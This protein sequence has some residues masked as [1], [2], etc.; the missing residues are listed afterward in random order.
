MKLP[1]TEPR[2]WAYRPLSKAAQQHIE[3]LLA[4]AGHESERVEA[5]LFGLNFV[6]S[7][8]HGHRRAVSAALPPPALVKELR[9]LVGEVAR[10]RHRLRALEERQPSLAALLALNA[11]PFPL[12]TLSGLLAGLQDG[13]EFLIG[14][15]RQGRGR[16][17][18]A[19]YESRSIAAV[20]TLFQQSLGVYPTA[21][22]GN[23]FET[24]LGKVLAATV[25][26][27]SEEHVHRL[28]ASV[29][30]SLKISE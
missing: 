17:A 25:G 19:D 13:A 22:Q 7:E 3:K 9:D 2:H 23:L 15:I 18:M 24:I 1:T 8:F 10:V 5:F 11:L 14:E 29:I 26:E 20:A 6:V 30:K 28:A 16:P 21:T 27:R 12:Q 4:D